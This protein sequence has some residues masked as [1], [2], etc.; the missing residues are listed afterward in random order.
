[1]VAPLSPAVAKQDVGQGQV[2]VSSAVLSDVSASPLSDMN[3]API[4]DVK[5]KKEHK[6]NDLPAVAAGGPEA[7]VQGTP[8]TGAAPA[9]TA[10]FDGIGVG[11]GSY[12]P[13]WAPPDT[14]GAVGPNH[15]VEI[16]N[17][18]IAVFDKTGALLYGPVPT[19]TLWSGFGGSCESRDDGDGIVEYDRQ[20]DRWVVTQFTNDGTNTECVAVSTGGDPRGSYARYAFTYPAFPDYPKLAVWPDAYYIT[21]NL[22]GPSGFAGGMVCAYDRTR[23]LLGQSATQ[24]CVNLGTGYAGLLP[25]DLD[26]STP[27]PA[28]SP[29]FVLSYGTNRLNLWKF[30]VDWANSANTKLTGPTAIPV[31]SFTRACPTGAACIAQPGTTQQLDSLADRLMSRLAY[32]NFGDHESLVVNHSVGTGSLSLGPSGIRWYEIRNP[33]ATPTVF[34]QGTYAPDTSTNRWMGSIAMDKAGNIA[35]GYSASSNTV[36][37]SIRYTGRL[38]G[39]PTGTMTQGEV[40]LQ[41]GVGSQL[42]SL[43]RWGDYSTM[44]VDPADDCTFWYANEYLKA[45][46]DWN[47]STRISSFKF[48]SCGATSVLTSITVSPSSASVQTGRT[49][50]FGAT[51]LDQFGI[52]VS[53]QPAFTWAVSGGGTISGTGLFTAGSTAGG[54]FTV[55][56]TSG[57]V[58]GTASVTV[59]ALP[60]DFSLAASP[61]SV[62]VRRGNTATYTVTVTP[63]NGFSGSVAL[64]LSGQPSGSTVTFTPGTTTSTSTLRVR[65]SS[66]GPRGTYTLTI[67]GKSGTLT[68]TATTSLTVTR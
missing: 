57:A 68:H 49:A 8:G 17:A 34:Q 54:P 19:N 9:P 33:N 16:V 59:T 66:S 5:E 65:T 37:P 32:R 18:D 35:V 40:V 1:M 3:P 43:S 4:V 24:Q 25:S 29:D 56:A 58:G 22:F 23:M 55:R 50:Q 51:G 48:P 21:F 2:V 38:A 10:S 46:G 47:W 36:R 20:A 14:Y 45:D 15:Y 53:P 13:R 67:T 41:A 63:S 31:A 12:S 27:P 42:P 7:A 39:D 26:G 44:T 64:T 52:P 6:K 60:A 28:G 11:L 30:H 62:S 61:A